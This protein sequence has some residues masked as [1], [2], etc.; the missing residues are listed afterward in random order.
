VE[1]EVSQSQYQL[2]EDIW[3]QVPTGRYVLPDGTL[4][5]EGA[6]VV[7]TLRVPSNAAVLLSEDD[8][9]LQGAEQALLKP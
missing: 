8:A 2:P 6:G 4:F 5:L 7:P 3:L 9:V 1:A